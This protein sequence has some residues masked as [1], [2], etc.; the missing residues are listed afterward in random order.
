MQ[1]TVKVYD[2]WFK[3][4]IQSTADHCRTV[5]K[6]CIKIQRKQIQINDK[7]LMS[8]FCGGKDIHSSA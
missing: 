4:S 1:L 7:T 3:N 8:L 2:V 5:S 6:V